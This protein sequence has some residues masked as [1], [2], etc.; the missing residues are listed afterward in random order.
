MN[1]RFVTGRVAKSGEKC[2]ECGTDAVSAFEINGKA[3][4]LACESH[5]IAVH[6]KAEK[7]LAIKTYVRGSKTGRVNMSR[8][9]VGQR[10]LVEYGEVG[11]RPASRKTGSMIVEVTG[12][13]KSGLRMW[14]LETGLGE[15]EAPSTQ[16]MWFMSA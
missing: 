4:G 5:I 6:D 3:V 13:R 14:I 9:S 11:L 7:S 16:C 12:K 1:D 2:S 10:I 8:V 15:I